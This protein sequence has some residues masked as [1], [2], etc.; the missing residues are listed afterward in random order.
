MEHHSE[1][2]AMIRTFCIA[3]L[4]FAA[5]AALAADAAQTSGAWQQLR[6]QFY[7]N[8]EIGEVDEKL[9]SVV[10]PGSTPDPTATPVAIRFGAQAAGEVRQVRV[11]IDHNPAPVAATMQLE[12]GVPIDEIELR[13][14]IDRATSVRAI[15]ELA[16]GSIEMRSA[17]VNASGGCSAPPSA[18]G[19]GVLGDIR[20]RPSSDGRALQMSVRHPNN[21]GFQIDP[22]SGDPIPPHFVSHLRVRAGDQTLIDADTG[23]SLSE[24]PTIRIASGKKLAAP[25]TLEAVDSAQAKFQATWSGAAPKSGGG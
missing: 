24:N 5:P 9:M 7:G 11:I 12:L 18:S 10:A 17:W 6:A 3:L 16:D 4:L 14:R 8:R 20:F 13:L 21:S 2:V 19:G 1:V 15:A 23:I 22:V 25:L